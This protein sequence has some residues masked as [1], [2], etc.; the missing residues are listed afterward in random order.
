MGRILMIKCSKLFNSMI[1]YHSHNSHQIGIYIIL[2]Q[3]N[4]LTSRSQM[5][6]IF[7]RRVEEIGG[8]E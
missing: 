7:T 5:N 6:L 1:E 8:D 2:A 4:M 3:L